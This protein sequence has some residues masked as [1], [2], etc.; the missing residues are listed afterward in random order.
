MAKKDLF[1]SKIKREVRKRIENEIRAGKPRQQ[2]LQE[3]SEEYMSKET[4]AHYI[5]SVLP[6][7]DSPKFTQKNN[8]LFYLILCFGIYQSILKVLFLLSTNLD[9]SK[10]WLLI[11]LAF[12][13]PIVIFYLAYMVRKKDG[14]IYALIV[15]FGIMGIGQLAR[16]E[17]YANTFNFVSFLIH[18]LWILAGMF[19]AN[20]ISKQYFPHMRWKAIG[21]NK[22]GK[23]ILSKDEWIA[24][25]SN[26]KRG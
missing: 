26:K 1:G 25:K 7:E 3:L 19:L 2:L 9:A 16:H 23:Y 12:I 5:A 6:P 24:I 4:L 8:V 21:L 15:L 13:Q 14:V 22:D 10:K 17:V 20:S 11:P 18:V